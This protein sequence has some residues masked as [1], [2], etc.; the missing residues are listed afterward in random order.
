M[1]PKGCPVAQWNAVGPGAR[2]TRGQVAEEPLPAGRGPEPC[3][4]RGPQCLLPSS[5]GSPPAL[6]SRGVRL[7]EHEH[8]APSTL[9]CRD[10]VG[11]PMSVQDPLWPAPRRRVPLELSLRSQRWTAVWLS[12]LGRVWDGCCLSSCDGGEVP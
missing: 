3:L 8:A 6:R 2:T 10:I 7:T 12:H 5:A 9:N 4:L 1:K 11:I